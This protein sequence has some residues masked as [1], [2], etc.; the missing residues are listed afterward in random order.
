MPS[1][2]TSTMDQKR[3]FIKDYHR[4]VCSMA[5]VCS[6]YGISRPTGDTWV[7]RFEALGQ[8]GLQERSRRP[9]GCSHETAIE[10]TEAL[11]ELRRKHPFWGPKKL[12]TV[13]RRRH[14]RVA[15]PARS[16]VADLLA[17]HGLIPQR[18]RRRYPGH[19]GK[20]SQSMDAPNDTWCID[21]KRECKT[22]NGLVLLSADGHRRLLPVH[23]GLSG[24]SVDRA[25]GGAAS[26]PARV[27]GVR[28]ADDHALR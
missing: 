12:L 11:L 1:S 14:P 18:R 26:P 8:S 9:H 5:E 28:S 13:L 4:G 27:P 23:P 6:R 7:D 24:P 2:E 21:F 20:P 10:V 19:P 22:G 16:T 15:W 17:R 3:L 25:R